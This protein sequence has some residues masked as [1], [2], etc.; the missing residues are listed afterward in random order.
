MGCCTG[1]IACV[2]AVRT[3]TF[4]TQVSMQVTKGLAYH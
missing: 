1:T 3:P 4:K 2:L